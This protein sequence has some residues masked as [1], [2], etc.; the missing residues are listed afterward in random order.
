MIDIH[1]HILYGI[2]DGS[3][4]IETSVNMAREAKN[5][6]FDTI[7][8]T[9]HFLE[10][11]FVSEKKDNDKILGELKTELIKQN[12]DINFVLGNEI[13]INTNILELLEYDK[14]SKMGESKYILIELPM[15]Q[16]LKYVKDMLIELVNKGLK[17]IIAHP[18]RYSYVQKDISY[19][20]DFIDMGVMFQ[21]NYAS[22]IGRY[23]SVAEKTVKKLLKRKMV[24]FM[25]SDA[26]RDNSIYTRMDKI[27]K[28]LK[29]IVDDEYYNLL[30]YENPKRILNNEDVV[31]LE[32]EKVQKFK[33]FK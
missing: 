10:P 14:V 12:V 18:E 7:I 1:S 19:L 15:N 26:H 16:E 4:T 30:T 8:C 9:P 2:D 23:G 27:L 17:I 33:L 28:K 29:K 32:F 24:Q 11:S 20:E 5:A 3:Q 25:A 31:V 21:C 13:Y 22:L 6:G